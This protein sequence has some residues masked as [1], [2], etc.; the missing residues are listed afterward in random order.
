MRR[1]AAFCGLPESRNL[2]TITALKR[3]VERL[4]RIAKRANPEKI[5]FITYWG[6]EMPED[7]REH[8]EDYFITD[9]SSGFLEG[10]EDEDE[11]DREL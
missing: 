8:Q 7:W 1:I 11:E 9:W 6:Y 2:S 10:D 4:A 5:T 3:K